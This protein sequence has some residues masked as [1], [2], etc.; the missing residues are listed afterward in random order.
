LPDTK[1]EGPAGTGSHLSS[2]D[3]EEET[4]MAGSKMAIDSPV[5]TPVTK[6]AELPGAKRSRRRKKNVKLPPLALRKD[7]G[8]LIFVGNKVVRGLGS[9]EA[10]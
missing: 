1:A 10:R 9:N 2:K 8:H 7:A 6:M 3:R 4:A 5:P